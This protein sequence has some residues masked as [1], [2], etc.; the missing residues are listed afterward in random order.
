MGL[1]NVFM[2]KLSNCDVLLDIESIELVSGGNQC[3]EILFVTKNN[4]KHKMVFDAVWDMRCSIENA[5]IERFC[6]FRE[7][8]PNGLLDNSIYIIEDS[9]YVKYFEKQVSGTRCVGN[10]KHYILYDRVDTVLDILTT[11]E[12]RLTRI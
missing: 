8:L 3:F 10:L 6:Q 9:E 5:S 1:E 4:E 7:C 11:E 2:A 12:P